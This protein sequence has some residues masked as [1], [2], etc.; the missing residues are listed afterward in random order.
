V[1]TKIQRNALDSLSPVQTLMKQ[2]KRDDWKFNYQQDDKE[3][4][5]HLFFFKDELSFLVSNC[6]SLSRIVSNCL[7]LPR[8]AFL[9]HLLRKILS[10]KHFSQIMKL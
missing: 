1:K 6:L 7:S 5:T 2:L 10:K 3:K 4:L 8:I 9:T